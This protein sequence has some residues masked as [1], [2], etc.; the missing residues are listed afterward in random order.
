MG[1]DF[2]ATTWETETLR[3]E[4]NKETRMSTT[5]NVCRHSLNLFP[6]S[7]TKKDKFPSTYFLSYWQKKKKNLFPQFYEAV[8]SKKSKPREQ[9]FGIV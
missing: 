2:A 8:E 5:N 9:V 6:Q 4:S 7:L 1:C 3:E